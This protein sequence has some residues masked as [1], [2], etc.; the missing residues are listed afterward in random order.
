MVVLIAADPKCISASGFP[1][2]VEDRDSVQ[3]IARDIVA[4]FKTTNSR[5]TSASRVRAFNNANRTMIDVSQS[6]TL[7][8]QAP[9]PVSIFSSMLIMET[10]DYWVIWIFAA[11]DKSELE[12]LKTT[13]IFF[14]NFVAPSREATNP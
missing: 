3:R 7:A 5:P 1:K 10:G 2:S 4:Y 13:K 11:G 6:F 8:S 12:G 14:D 9:T